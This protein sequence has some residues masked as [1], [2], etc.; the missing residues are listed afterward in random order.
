M[1]TQTKEKNTEQKE[2]LVG[3]AVISM[4]LI[5]FGFWVMNDSI[6]S[7]E[8]ELKIYSQ[9]LNIQNSLGRI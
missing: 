2:L 7:A 5:F 3:Y 8:Q 6:A 4:F 9:K 1:K